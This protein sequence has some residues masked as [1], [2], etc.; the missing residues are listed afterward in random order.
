MSQSSCVHFVLAAAVALVAACGDGKNGGASPQA[1]GGGPPAA[2][3][4]IQTVERKPIERSSEL[5]ATIKS[6]HSTTVQP[7]VD[8]RVTRIFVKAGDR[9][10]VG[11]PLLQIDPEK[12]AATVINTQSQRAA[13]QGDV[14]YWKRQLERLR[15]LLGAG[16]ISRNEFDTAQH[17]LE[18]AQ[19]NLAALDAQVREGQVQLQ[20]YRV[21]APQDGIVG[22]IAIREGDRVTP[23]T[24]ITTIDDRE[25]L[26]AYL[27]V[28]L[29]RAP[30][31]HAGVPVQILDPDGRVAA[32]NPITFVAPRVDDA[33]QTVL[34]KAQLRDVPPTLRVQQFI[35]ARIVWSSQPGLTLPIV[36][37]LRLGGQYF[38][39]VAEQS[40]NGLV[41]RQRPVQVG[42]MLGNDYVV[43]GG[44]K[45]GDRVIVSGVQKL[46]DG[47]PVRA[48]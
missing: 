25:G 5:I 2:A 28:P 11:T 31:L 6:L 22:D 16:A 46:A 48:E 38:C 18:T 45:E 3:V 4:K 37:V 26:E 33:T 27:Q 41:A 15:S 29:T 9:V 7:Q 14:E 36:A 34:A 12:Q 10:R 35:R 21:T 20:Y 17:N 47:A 1:A 39:F 44:L 23:A 43:S 8:G 13:R 42:E 40:E 32:T 30:E 24:A 19:A